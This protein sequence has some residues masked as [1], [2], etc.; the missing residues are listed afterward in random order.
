MSIDIVVAR[1]SGA[2]ENE[3]V[4]NTENTPSPHSKNATFKNYDVES[5]QPLS[6]LALHDEHDDFAEED[7]HHEE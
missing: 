5:Q 7:D 2:E 6:L 3:S 1:K 4:L